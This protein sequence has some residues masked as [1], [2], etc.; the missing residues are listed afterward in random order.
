MDF[1]GNP[2]TNELKT[3]AVRS[4][5]V[6]VFATCT[7]LAQLEMLELDLFE[8]WATDTVCAALRLW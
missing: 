5:V 1:T 4:R 8:G 7:P 3:V 6:L 2:M